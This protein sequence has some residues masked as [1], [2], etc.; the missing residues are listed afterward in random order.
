MQISLAPRIIMRMP[1]KITIKLK[2]LIKVAKMSLKQKWRL[3]NSANNFNRA[4]ISYLLSAM[5]SYDEN[6]C[7]FRLIYT[8]FNLKL[9]SVHNYW[10]DLA[11]F[12]P[13][14]FGQNN[15]NLCLKITTGVTSCPS[16]VMLSP[17]YGTL[18]REGEMLGL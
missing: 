5:T 16:R 13:I 14:K 3:T 6:E 18:C 17:K 11:S 2:K 15:V 8:K 4:Q 12:L 9:I 1:C 10:A 7:H